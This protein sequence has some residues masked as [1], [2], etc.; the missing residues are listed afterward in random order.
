VDKAQIIDLNQKT[1][2][3]GT[4]VVIEGGKNLE[5]NIKRVFYMYG[6]DSA[7][8]RGQHANRK[9]IMCFICVKGSCSIAV[10]NGTEKR[11][12]FLGNPAKGLVCESMTWKEMSGFSSD[13]VLMVMCDTYYDADEY[14]T[15]YGIFVEESKK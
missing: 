6:M 4:L 2:S 12:F 5:F 13:C 8:I 3:R 15:D 11:V 14:I 7:S 9:S 1:D 10:D